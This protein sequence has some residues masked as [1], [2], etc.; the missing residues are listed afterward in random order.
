M[1]FEEINFHKINRR[2]V[3]D[4]TYQTAAEEWN[5]LGAEIQRHRA[6]L[7]NIENIQSGGQGDLSEFV[8][9]AEMEE[10]EARISALIGA[11]DMRLITQEEYASISPKQFK[12][13]FVAKDATDKAK[14]KC[15]KIYLRTQLVGMF[16]VDGSQTLPKFPMRFPFRLA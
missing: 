15:W 11:V 9:D 10:Y 6:R 4:N 14:G 2:P 12:Y 1:N 7:N 3:T 16:N 8:T 13:Y 5:A